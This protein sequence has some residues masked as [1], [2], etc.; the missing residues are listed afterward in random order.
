M[1]NVFVLYVKSID[2]VALGLLLTRSSTDVRPVWYKCQSD[3][4]MSTTLICKSPC[5]F[6]LSDCC[7]GI[8]SS[9]S[10]STSG[11]SQPPDHFH[12]LPVIFVQPHLLKTKT[13]DNVRKMNSKKCP[14][15]KWLVFGGLVG[16][17]KAVLTFDG[18]DWTTGRL[19]IGVSI[20]IGV[21]LMTPGDVSLEYN[22]FC[23]TGGIMQ[24]MLGEIDGVRHS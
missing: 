8:S 15:W 18:W 10:S 21:T 7:S 3:G 1:R 17:I 12:I 5:L 19:W 2:Y 14:Q 6:V 20:G 11:P 9:R 23:N 4:C 24:W 13:S 16:T 22:W